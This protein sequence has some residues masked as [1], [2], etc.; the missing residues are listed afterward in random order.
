MELPLA[1]QLGGSLALQHRIAQWAGQALQDRGPQQEPP[2]VLWLAGQHLGDQIAGDVAVIGPV[3]ATA[4][5]KT[6]TTWVP[7]EPAKLRSPPTAISP[8]TRPC[9]W[10][11]VPNGR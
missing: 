1:E 7:R 5:W 10:A 11:V 3:R 4:S 6:L 9:L 2:D 8:A